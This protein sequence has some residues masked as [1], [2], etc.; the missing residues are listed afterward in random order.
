MHFYVF[1]SKIGLSGVQ[2]VHLT[3]PAS[4][5]GVYFWHVV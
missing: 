3:L 2:F 5:K 4:T 1:K